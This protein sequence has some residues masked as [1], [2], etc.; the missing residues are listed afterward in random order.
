MEMNKFNVFHW[1][2]TDDNSFPYVS[3]RFPNLRWGL[4]E[5]LAQIS[6]LQVLEQKTCICKTETGNE[7]TL[8]CQKTFAPNYLRDPLAMGPNICRK[9]SKWMSFE[10]RAKM[11]SNASNWGRAFNLE[12]EGFSVQWV[13]SPPLT[14]Y[15]HDLLHSS[16][17]CNQVSRKKTTAHF[18]KFPPSNWLWIWRKIASFPKQFRRSYISGF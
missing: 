16:P 8:T 15:H 6:L 17:R 13:A 3:K 18:E 9:C 11:S 2:M 14:R 10:R 5:M 12:G 4:P 7:W 1:H